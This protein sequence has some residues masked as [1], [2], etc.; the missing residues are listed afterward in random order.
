M[1]NVLRQVLLEQARALTAR[2]A[3]DGVLVLSGLVSTDVPELSAH[4]APLFAGRR[5]EIYERAE[6]R[7]LVWRSQSSGA[8]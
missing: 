6:W 2:L 7:A 8:R 4:Y 3:P 5:P 1:A